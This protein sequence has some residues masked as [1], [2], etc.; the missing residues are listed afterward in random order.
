MKKKFARRGLALGLALAMTLGL[1]AC[2]GEEE[3]QSM[4]NASLA[5]E[6]VYRVQNIEL[7]QLNNNENSYTNIM[8]TMR[9]D[10]KILVLMQETSWDNETGE[11]NSSY[12]LLS[13]NEDGSGQEATEIQIPEESGEEA[14][15]EAGG[16]S[17]EDES[18]VSV[19]E[20]TYY[21]NFVWN[22]EGNLYGLKVYNRSES[23][24]E[25]YTSQSAYY[26]C[27]WDEDGTFL[28]EKQLEGIVQ[29]ENSWHY[30]DTIVAGQ[31]G[32]LIILVRGDSG[33]T[34]TVDAEGN[35]S[36]RA[37]ISEDVESAF[38]NLER[39][40]VREDGALLVLYHDE[41]NWQKT[42]CAEYDIAS[43]RLGESIEL[44]SSIFYSWDYN[45]MN[46]GENNEL[47]YTASS[48]LYSYT[49]GDAEPELKMDYINSDL[50]IS[51]F[52]QIVQLSDTS[53]IGIYIEDWSSGMKAGIFTYVDPADIQD[54]AVIVL[55]GN[56][57]NSDVK[58]RVIEYNRTSQEYRIVTKEYSAYN[59]YEDY[60]A[61]ITRL[62][63][64]IITGNMPDILINN[65][66]NSLPIENYIAKGLIA[67]V[68]KLIESDEELSQVEFMQN[69]FD[70]YSVDGT[71]YYVV[72]NFEV[73]TMV[74]K[75]SLVGDRTSW[76]MEDMQQVLA[77]MGEEATAFGD[78][79]R[80]SF[81]YMVM[82]YCGN[83][84]VD[85]STGKCSFNTEDFISMMEFANT[86]PQE[87]SYDD[88]YWMN[89]DW[90]AEQ[91]RYREN[92][93][94]LYS[95]NLYYFPDIA[96]IL[97]GYF[98]EPVSFVG[99]PSESGNG[100]YLQSSTTYAL[101]A[102]SK[103][104]EGAWDFVRYYLTEE[105]QK[106][107]GYFPVNK[108]LFTE[109]SKD[110]MERPYWEDENGEKQYYDNTMTINGENIVISPLT[111]E[112]L[113][114]VVEFI[115][116]V[117]NRYYYNESVSNIVNEEMGAYYSGQKSAQDVANIIQSRVQIYVDENR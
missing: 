2:G 94:L 27:R 117:N 23:T 100:S 88:D 71:L 86:L 70:A 82:R 72:P 25:T 22:T 41:N 16:E 69:V 12:Y 3:G 34:L 61:G 111:Q 20:N 92:R 110:A 21:T 45:V 80:D 46:V 39:I 42:Y 91:S 47:I 51:S 37:E 48:G 58:K 99:F 28:W 67:D 98:G 75:E 63:N 76:T 4:E 107:V 83:Q 7:P 13:M 56:W 68:G 54:K 11:S 57:I 44:P 84:F 33:F 17:Q 10:G 90:S 18:Y 55:A 43:G 115:E 81:M 15:G 114:Q 79:T 49:L 8:Q 74:A 77:G 19:W 31:D 52:Y 108:A 78:T 53:F 96:M 85:V 95:A 50:Y 36:E 6:H 14:G 5:K 9:R 65:E 59:T 109:L 60:S 102:K 26:I 87:I 24:A 105:Y 113:D 29:D 73:Y 66:Y 106:E 103:N 1:C 101:S 30:V 116:S 32:S 104:L 89:Y 112:Q 40:L 64:D 62:N 35:A 97:N 38:N 93:T